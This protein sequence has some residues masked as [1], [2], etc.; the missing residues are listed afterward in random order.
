VEEWVECALRS[1]ASPIPRIGERPKNACICP[2]DPS[3]R[4]DEPRLIAVISLPAPQLCRVSGANSA[5]RQ[6]GATPVPLMWH[7]G[8]C[9]LAEQRKCLLPRFHM[10]TTGSCL[11]TR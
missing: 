10:P 4:V 11:M 7:T 5:L 1:L 2:N 8:H 9:G 6:A 3:S